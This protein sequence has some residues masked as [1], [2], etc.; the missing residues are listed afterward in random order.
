MN[1]VA[2]NGFFGGV[3]LMIAP[4]VLK[5][6]VVLHY[7]TMRVNMILQVVFRELSV[8][9]FSWYFLV[10]YMIRPYHVHVL[11]RAFGDHSAQ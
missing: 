10:A 4:C 1:R 9:L 2:C 8:M 7:V 3:R 11:L 5:Q 6:A